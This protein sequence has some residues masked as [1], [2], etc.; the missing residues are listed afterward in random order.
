MLYFRNHDGKKKKKKKNVS[1]KKRQINEGCVRLVGEWGN[2]NKNCY[3]EIKIAIHL[4]IELNRMNANKIYFEL[5]NVW[6]EFYETDACITN[7]A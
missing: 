5:L 3:V 6:T 7:N 1:T 2:K 4:N